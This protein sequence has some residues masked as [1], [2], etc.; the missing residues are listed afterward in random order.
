MGDIDA[1]IAALIDTIDGLI[2]EAITMGM[3]IVTTTDRALLRLWAKLVIVACVTVQ[4]TAFERASLK[5]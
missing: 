3:L 4:P 2:A 1:F 5:S